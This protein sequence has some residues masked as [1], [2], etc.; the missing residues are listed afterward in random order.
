M[1][2]HLDLLLLRFIA[3]T[4][5]TSDCSIIPLRR[6]ADA[7]YDSA[8]RS[9]VSIPSSST[10]DS[11]DTRVPSSKSNLLQGLITVQNITR[12]G[13]SSSTICAPL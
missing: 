5:K 1:D 4:I 13:Q 12:P 7:S 8:R 11:A 9:L 10:F 2:F 3:C 6:D